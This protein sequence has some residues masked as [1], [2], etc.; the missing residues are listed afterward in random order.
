MSSRTSKTE[1]HSPS[2]GSSSALRPVPLMPQHVTRAADRGLHV[3]GREIKW[4]FH[5]TLPSDLGSYCTLETIN[6]ITSTK[7]FGKPSCHFQKS[8]KMT[9]PPISGLN[10][11]NSMWRVTNG[12]AALAS[13]KECITQDQLPPVCQ[14][15]ASALLSFSPCHHRT[16]TFPELG[17]RLQGRQTPLP[18]PQPCQ[19]RPLPRALPRRPLCAGPTEPSSSF[20]ASPFLICPGRDHRP[21]LLAQMSAPVSPSYLYVC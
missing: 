14:E 1:A 11:P 19:P 13:P 15:H 9:F 21:P 10:P 5:Q 12:S 17:L 2:Q 16:T 7:P 20:H 3:Y 4:L 6:W 8:R 18:A